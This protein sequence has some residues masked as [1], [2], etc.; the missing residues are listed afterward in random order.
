MIMG[1]TLPTDTQHLRIE[2]RQYEL[3]GRPLGQG[4]NRRTMAIWAGTATVWFALLAVCGVSPFWRFGP[5]L[6]LVPVS[7][8][9][10]AGTR[11]DDSGRMQLMRWWDWILARSRPRRRLISNPLMSVAASDRQPFRVHVIAEVRPGQTGAAAAQRPRRGRPR[12]R[13]ATAGGGAG[14]GGC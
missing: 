9:V 13:A 10:L 14:R 4:I 11:V 6:Y 8:A 1:L 7:L 3:M 2:T 5:P 12:R